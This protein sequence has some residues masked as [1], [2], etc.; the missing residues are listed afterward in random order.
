MIVR[1][2]NKTTIAVAGVSLLGLLLAFA[3]V[4][5]YA[6]QA[7][8]PRSDLGW[9]GVAVEEV[10]SSRAQELK[11]PATRGV[12]I[13]V[14]N[15]DSP[16][17]KAGLQRGDVVTEYGGRQV[18]GILEFR[19]LVRETPPGRTVQL[20]VW[21]NGHSLMLQATV[22]SA[23]A[24]SGN[25]FGR[26]GGNAF[27]YR[28]PQPGLTPF[29]G[30]WWRGFNMPGQGLRNTPLLGISA[31]DLSGQLGQYFA[32]PNGQGVLVTDVHQGSPAEKAGIRAGDVITKLDG[33][34]VR[35]IGELQMRLRDK[36]NEKTV[37]LSVLR[38]GAEMSIH[39]AP[40]EPQAPRQF[41]SFNSRIPL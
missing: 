11:L 8:R 12:F 26:N 40:E 25:G 4:R 13:S 14:V 35:N 22:G 2:V 41:N 10:T 19:R 31:Q 21:R 29:A 17:A 3:P 6:Q 34:P 36:R 32:A 9:L 16:A 33:Q 28:M 20:T 27:G 23:P 1:T 37:T 7:A 30:R 38:K 18:E 39:V 5:S 24:R 15:D